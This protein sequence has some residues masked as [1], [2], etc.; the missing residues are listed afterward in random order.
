M[1]ALKD[2]GCWSHS[3]IYQQGPKHFR[4]KWLGGFQF[5]FGTVEILAITRGCL[6]WQE[7]RNA[8]Q[9]LW[10]DAIVPYTISEELGGLLWLWRALMCDRCF[11]ITQ[12]LHC[13][14]SNSLSRGKHPSRLQDDIRLHVHSLPVAHRRVQ[15]RGVCER[16]RV[17]NAQLK[18]RLSPNT[19][20]FSGHVIH[21]VLVLSTW[22]LL[23]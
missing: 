19:L 12:Q 22:I 3:R 2:T 11:Q 20:I 16:Q 17:R 13:F 8:V 7:D 6:N 21:E 14:I 9:T 1:L 15:L 5:F 10:P 18:G 4:I 23:P